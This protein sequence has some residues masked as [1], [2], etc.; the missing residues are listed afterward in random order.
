MVKNKICSIYPTFIHIKVYVVC[1]YVTNLDVLHEICGSAGRLMGCTSRIWMYV[2]K[3]RDPQA[4]GWGFSGR[5][6]CRVWLK[7][8]W[9]FVGR[10]VSFWGGV[11]ESFKQHEALCMTS[12]TALAV[13]CEYF[14]IINIFC[15][16][17]FFN[18]NVVFFKAKCAL[19]DC[20]WR[21][22]TK[23]EV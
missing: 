15:D 1:L 14:Y 16:F 4:D 17:A 11:G 12:K 22:L 3:F 7:V 5:T 2:T 13:F 10:G 21:L 20:I 23:C 9:K 19:N 18:K 8:G 6:W